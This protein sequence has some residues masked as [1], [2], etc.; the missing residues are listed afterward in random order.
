MLG[1]GA[2]ILA[3]RA[4][5]GAVK[6]AFDPE[7]KDGSPLSPDNFGTRHRPA[8]RMCASLED[9]IAL[10]VSQDGP[11]KAIKR[12]G[13]ALIVWNDVTLGRQTL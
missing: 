2:E 7:G 6:L 10:V 4:R 1:F 9:C 5:W 13:T 8:M 11:V 3:N 12:V